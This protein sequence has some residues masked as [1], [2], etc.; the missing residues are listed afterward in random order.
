LNRREHE[1]VELEFGPKDEPI[2]PKANPECVY[3]QKERF[4]QLKAAMSQLTTQQYNCILLRTQGLRYREIGELL[5]I[6]EQ[7]AI[8]L[9][10]R[11]MQRLMGGL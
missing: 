10:K 2:D 7:R 6:S 8:H 4:G 1:E 9:V 3:L 11:G 5:G